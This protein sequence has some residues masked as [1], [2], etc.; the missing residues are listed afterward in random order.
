MRELLA[1]DDDEIE[2]G[3]RDLGLLLG[4]E[5]LQLEGPRLGVGERILAGFLGLKSRRA[6]QGGGGREQ[7]G[8]IAKSTHET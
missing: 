8:G 6:E 7:S 1:V 2:R 3:G 4:A 5:V